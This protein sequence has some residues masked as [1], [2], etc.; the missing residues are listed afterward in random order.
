[1]FQFYAYEFVKAIVVI[2]VQETSAG[3][4]LPE[5]GRIRFTENH[6]AMAC[7]VHIGIEKDVPAGGLND[8]LFGCQDYAQFL[9]AELDKVG[10]GGFVRVPVAT[11]VV[12][13]FRE[14]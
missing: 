9:A 8:I 12:F 1:F 14:F 6:V 7:H 2:D 11:A 5:V 13:K 3:K 10:K 4:I